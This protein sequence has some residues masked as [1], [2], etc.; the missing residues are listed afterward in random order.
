MFTHAVFMWHSISWMI[1]NPQMWQQKITDIGEEGKYFFTVRTKWHLCDVF[2]KMRYLS[3][4]GALP[5]ASSVESQITV[6]NN[7]AAANYF[8]VMCRR[9]RYNMIAVCWSCKMLT[10]TISPEGCH[11]QSATTKKTDRS[12]SADLLYAQQGDNKRL[13]LWKAWLLKYAF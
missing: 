3:C 11:E 7:V 2:S 13:T 8:T 9:G 4:G 6:Q 5:V 10:H 12:R 1:W